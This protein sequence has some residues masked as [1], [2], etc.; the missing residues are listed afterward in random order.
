MYDRRYVYPLQ[1]GTSSPWAYQLNYFSAAECDEI[2]KQG[3]ELSAIVGNVGSE[4]QIDSGVRQST[5]SFFDPSSS[6]SLWIYNRIRQAA[7]DINR[8]FWNFDLTYI[9]CLQF[10]RYD[11]VGDFY[12]AHVDMRHMPIEMRKLS[13]S[14][15]LSDENSYEGS[16][17]MM[18]RCGQDYDRAPRN[19]GSIIVFP[20]YQVHE[21]APL[22][23]GIRYSL[24]AWMIGPPFR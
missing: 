4:N 11:K 13:I 17:L 18:F 2:I 14:V 15:Q 9:E 7:T 10:T 3:N 23:S 19:K 1:P 8:Q 20:A 5:V 12:A 24:V 21:V 6:R 22:V 16:D